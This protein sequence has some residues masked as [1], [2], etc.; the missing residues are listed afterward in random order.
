MTATCNREN[1]IIKGA[2]APNPAKPF[3]KGLSENFYLFKEKGY[4]FRSTLFKGL[5]GLGQSPKTL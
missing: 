3:E 5:R 4:K 1:D 2:A